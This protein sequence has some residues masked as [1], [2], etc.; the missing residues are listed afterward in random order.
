M[1]VSLRTIFV[2]EPAD[3]EGA[4]DVFTY[5]GRL[6][7]ALDDH[8]LPDLGNISGLEP[9]EVFLKLSDSNGSPVARVEARLAGRP[10]FPANKV[11]P[12]LDRGLCVSFA[13]D[14]NFWRGYQFVQPLF[15]RFYST[16]LSTIRRELTPVWM[17]DGGGIMDWRQ[18]PLARF[19]YYRDSQDFAR[20]LLAHHSLEGDPL[21]VAKVLQELAR[22]DVLTRYLYEKRPRAL[23][24]ESGGGTWRRF[25]RLRLVEQGA[26]ILEDGRYG[27]ESGQAYGDTADDL[28]TALVDLLIRAKVARPHHNARSAS[29]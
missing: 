1:S 23:A 10:G 6:E 9:T 2:T 25:N 12:W 14:W 19:V 29:P 3:G 17:V 4:M 7:A 16:L 8:P 5:L 15:Q 27:S 13:W 20:S 22:R 21:E 28:R 11:P 18:E 24:L 26:V